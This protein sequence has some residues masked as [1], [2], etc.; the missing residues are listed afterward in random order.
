[1]RE[2]TELNQL[3]SGFP[4]APLIYL[5]IFQEV[6]LFLGGGGGVGALAHQLLSDCDC[7]MFALQ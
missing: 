1:M 5:I 2:C 3:S 7:M 4:K 6:V